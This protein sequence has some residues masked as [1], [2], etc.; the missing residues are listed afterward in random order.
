MC[1]D[2]WVFGIF[3]LL[4]IAVIVIMGV[5]GFNWG[6]DFIGGMVIEIMFEKLVEIDVMCDV[7]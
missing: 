4:L 3:G 2:Y 6:L 7:L 1:W 5:C